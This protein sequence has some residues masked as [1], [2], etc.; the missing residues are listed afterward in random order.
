MRKEIKNATQDYYDEFNLS[1]EQLNKLNNLSQ[2]SSQI[3]SSARVK[4]A[5]IISTGWKSFLIAASILFSVGI[6]FYYP[7]YQKNQLILSIAEEVTK[8]HIKMK[9]LDI[10][11][12]LFSDIR[13]GLDKL[14]FI[15]TPSSYYQS[16]QEI[17]AGARYCSIKSVTAAQLRFVNQSQQYETLYQ[18][19]YDKNTFGSIP[20]VTTGEQPLLRYIKGVKVEIWRES[21]LMMISTKTQ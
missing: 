11:S 7:T 16:K 13:Q 10:H 14:D 19:P 21:G 12:Q 9:P 2:P 1:E 6:A 8:N 18:V 3:G 15:P 20:D 17:L 5:T 4:S